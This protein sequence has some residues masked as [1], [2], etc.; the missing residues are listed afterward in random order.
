MSIR[1][2]ELNRVSADLLDIARG[3]EFAESVQDGFRR[4]ADFANAFFPGLTFGAWTR[5]AQ[6]GQ[7][8]NAFVTILP[9]DL[10]R[11]IFDIH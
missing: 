9:I 10:H 5:A 3:F 4:F 11:A 6:V 7:I 8:V 2:S 1:P